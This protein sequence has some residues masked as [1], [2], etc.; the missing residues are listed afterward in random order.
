MSANPDSLQKSPI[1]VHSDIDDYG[2]RSDEFRIFARIS[3]RG[4]CTESV[5]S[6]AAGCHISERQVRYALKVLV[7]CRLIAAEHRIGGTSIYRLRPASDWCS[8]EQYEYLRKAALTANPDNKPLHKGTAHAADG[9]AGDAGLQ[10]MQEGAAMPA[11][12]AAHAAAKGTPLKVLPEGTPKE[13]PNGDGA[14]N[15]RRPSDEDLEFFRRRDGLILYL[16][17]RLKT[18]KLPN[19]KG[20]KAAVLRLVKQ[21]SDNACIEVLDYQMGQKWR[22][23]A[24]WLTVEQYIPH[25]LARK[26]GTGSS[27]RA[28]DSDWRVRARAGLEGLSLANGQQ[29]EIEMLITRLNELTLEEFNNQI[30]KLDIPDDLLQPFMGLK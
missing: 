29:S 3:R 19:L 7:T 1:F 20:Q 12:G 10:E 9:T 6:M 16:K 26:N 22:D 17:E 14:E 27:N 4:E 24:D 5:A 11:G 2:L 21:Y 23:K 15:P 25:Y 8:T 18:D 28:R 13:S 30:W